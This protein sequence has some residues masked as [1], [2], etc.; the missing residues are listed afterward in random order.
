MNIVIAGA[1]EVGSHLAKMLAGE[2]HDITII[3]DD[4]ERLDAVAETSD[5]LTVQG[6]PT[7]IEVL[8]SAAVSKADLFVAIYPSKS[9]NINIISALLAKQVGAKKV[10]CRINN[11]E[12]MSKEN[13][14]IFTDLGIDKLFYPER[15]ASNE[16][17]N[18]LKQAEMTEF[19][20]LES[21]LCLLAL[22][23]ELESSMLDNEIVD[24]GI[25]DGRAKFRIVAI[26][27]G[28]D[29]FI[30]DELTRIRLHDMLYIIA[31]RDSVDEVIRLVG[32]EEFDVHRLIILGGGRIGEQLAARFEGQAK[33]VKLIEISRERCTEL[34]KRLTKTL[35]INGDGRNSDFLY[36]EDIK[37]CDAFVAVTS[38]SETNILSCIAAKRMGVPKTIAEVENLKYVKLAEEMGVDAVI[39][40]K[41]LTASDLFRFAMADNVHRVKR[42]T[43]SDAKIIEYVANAG[44]TITSAPLSQIDFPKD[45]VIGGVAR[46]TD[47]YVTTPDT[48]I[49]PY[50]RVFVFALTSALQKL[51]KL[52]K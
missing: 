5:L 40:K 38:S 17:V 8:R 45:A 50:D 29:T 26:T 42:L 48:Q 24:Y 21:N 39:N 35:I 37:S 33:F 43:G 36:E 10:A 12:F 41:L 2:H 47:S 49:R 51:D 32:K 6:D 7:S 31:M 52:F 4:L 46:G 15:M 1:G 11:G 9:Q 22:R 20:K 25:E 44:S 19:A 3:D 23:V 30:P 28:D 34:S 27:R 18:L 16:I 14:T 13:K